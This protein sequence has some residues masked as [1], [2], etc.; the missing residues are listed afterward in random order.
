MFVKENP[1][2]EKT[3]S[4]GIRWNSDVFE[5]DKKVKEMLSKVVLYL[6]WII[7]FVAQLW[8]ATF[9]IIFGVI[10]VRKTHE[11]CLESQIEPCSVAV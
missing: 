2:G 1:D 11:S 3:K 9:K 7:F 6:D 10:F 5:W 4:S 8:W